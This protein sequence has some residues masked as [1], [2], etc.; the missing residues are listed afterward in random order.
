MF[1]KI[2]NIICDSFKILIFRCQE[3]ALT[4]KKVELDQVESNFKIVR[5][6]NG[7]TQTKNADVWSGFS[8]IL[9]EV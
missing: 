3:L 8:S 5:E 7:F 2:T 4:L 9:Q 6:T 1:A